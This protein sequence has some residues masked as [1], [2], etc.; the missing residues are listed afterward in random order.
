MKIR[1]NNV[2][3]ADG[4]QD[5]DAIVIGLFAVHLSFSDWLGGFSVTHVPTG[6]AIRTSLTWAQ[7]CRLLD[8]LLAHQELDWTFTD[9]QQARAL[10]D[11]IRPIFAEAGV[12][13]AGRTAMSGERRA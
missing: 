9:P 4:Y 5:T 13:W 11:A 3:K 10:D 7:A 6:W 2:A 12:I 1:A 8:A